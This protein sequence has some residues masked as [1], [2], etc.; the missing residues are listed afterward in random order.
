MP[1]FLKNKKKKALFLLIL[2]VPIGLCLLRLYYEAAAC[3]IL[4]S[5]VYFLNKHILHQINKPLDSLSPQRPVSLIDTLIIGDMCSAE[6][7]DRFSAIDGRLSILA[8][9]RSLY[10]S[11]TIL[12]H[13]ASVLSPGGTVIIVIPSKENSSRLTVFDSPFI[14]YVTSLEE[15][16]PKRS[17]KNS[18][19]L[20]FAPVR[21][22][23][24]LMGGSR[25]KEE[26]KCPDKELAD[27]CRRKGFKLI[28]LQ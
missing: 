21:S 24:M 11:S 1:W 10:S 2:I 15:G 27:Y 6:V 28:C 20:V 12:F 4:E 19:P 22:I 13:T 23:K 8:P 17:M 3:L 18:F 26:I 14:S 7:L 9:E 16:C 25:R 5:C